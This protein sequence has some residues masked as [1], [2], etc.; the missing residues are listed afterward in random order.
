[1]PRVQSVVKPNL[2]D[3]GDKPTT[4]VMLL[5]L[6]YFSERPDTKFLNAPRGN[7][8][9]TY[10]G[11]GAEDVA[12][13]IRG[14]EVPKTTS[15]EVEAFLRAVKGEDISTRDVSI[16][17]AHWT[18]DRVLRALIT[19]DVTI[20]SSFECVGHIAHLN[21]RD[22]HNKYKKIIGEVMLDKL[23]PRITSIVN[24]LQ[25]TGGPYRTFSMEV[26]A[27]EDIMQTSVR[28][29]GCLFKLDFAK[30]YWNS[31]LETEH[32]RIINSLK[33]DDILADAFCGIG[34]FV[35][36][37]AKQKRCKMVYAND[38]NPSSVHY[39][40]ENVKGNNVEEDS[41]ETSCSCAR[42]FLKRI[43]EEQNVGITRVVMN[44][45][46]G[47]PEFLDVFR[48]LYAGREVKSVIMPVVH[49]YCFVKGADDM[50]SARKRVRKALFGDDYEGM[51]EFGDEEMEVRDVR[52]VAPRKRQVCVTFRVP[53]T[54]ALTIREE[55]IEPVEKR[56]KLE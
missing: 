56:Q 4:P 14:W 7:S 28:E 51:E 6:K 50:D 1:M 35:I 34:P 21:L 52:D 22:E 41:I 27:G 39:L 11:R 47:A 26:L 29:N 13:R 48:G 37:A 2:A 19:E 36:P 54:V 5:L 24:K 25:S 42:E 16:D 33:E 15:V 49:C 18:T 17:Y 31:R 40:R 30:V 20:P 45:P 53:E 38:L 10:A 3:I 32:R 44:F 55:S 46:S 12:E 43:V 8:D 9:A 23:W